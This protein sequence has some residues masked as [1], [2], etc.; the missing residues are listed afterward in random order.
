LPSGSTYRCRGYKT[1]FSSSTML[2]WNKLERGQ[3]RT[4]T[5]KPEAV[6]LVVCDHF[7]NKL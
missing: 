7:M 1:V 4:D 2:R 6:F 3:T 5:T